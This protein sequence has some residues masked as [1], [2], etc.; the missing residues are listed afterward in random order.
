MDTLTS[1]D[2]EGMTLLQSYQPGDSSCQEAA[3]VMHLA[4]GRREKAS[5]GETMG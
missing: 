3:V 5:Q 2:K 1:R 4:R